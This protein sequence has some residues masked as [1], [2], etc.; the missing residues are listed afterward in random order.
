MAPT[1]TPTA[2]G[3]SNSAAITGTQFAKAPAGYNSTGY[4]S[5]YDSLGSSQADY[6]SKGNSANSYSN[7]QQPS[8]TSGNSGSVS[9][10]SSNAGNAD[11]SM[12]G[13]SHASLTKVNG[14]FVL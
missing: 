9:G 7:S 14:L 5:Q 10:Q 8:K 1:A 13:K 6:S 3:A 2:P 11:L 4:A 12:Y